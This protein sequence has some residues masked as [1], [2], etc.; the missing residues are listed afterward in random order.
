M[1]AE[2]RQVQKSGLDPHSLITEIM[3]GLM[4]LATVAIPVAYFAP[5]QAWLL[6]GLFVFALAATAWIRSICRH[7]WQFLLVCLIVIALPLVLP[8]LPSFSDTIWP[9]LIALPVL[10]FICSRALFLRLK[11]NE[12]KPLSDPVQQTLVILYLLVLN[13]LALRLDLTAVSRAYFYIGIL[14]LVLALYRWHRLA[15]ASQ[16]E[17]FL[18]M[19]TQPADR[20]IH[21]NRILLLGYGIVILLILLISPVFHLHDLLPWIGTGLLAALRWLVR[22]L[23]KDNGQAPVEPQPEPTTAPSE[24]NPQ[25]PFAPTETARWLEILQQIFQYLLIGFV[26]AIL[27]A[28]I[29]AILRSLYKRFYESAQPASDKMESLLP[30]FTKQTKEQLQRVRKRFNSQFSQTPAQRVRRSFYRLLETQMRR[31][32]TVETS[33]TPGQIMAA[34]DQAR[35]PDLAQIQ[36]VYEAARYGPDISTAEDAERMQAWYRQLR[37]QDLRLHQNWGKEN[38]KTAQELPDQRKQPRRFD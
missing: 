1:S 22:L 30:S 38:K 12:D 28:L 23:S 6:Y 13:L 27:L 9:R 26:A 37:K 11:Q 34:L 16:L 24:F 4:I 29:Y 35:Y 32:L 15:L 8:I 31:G 33:Q 10:V 14:Y 5:D 2:Q 7:I 3:Q 25:L 19:P 17:R 36:A 21:F 20:I 18:N